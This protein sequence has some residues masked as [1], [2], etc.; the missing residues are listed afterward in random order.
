MHLTAVTRRTFRLIMLKYPSLFSLSSIFFILFTIGCSR[1]ILK[2]PEPLP[3]I[4]KEY[5][6]TKVYGYTPGMQNTGVYLKEGDFY[7]LFGSGEIKKRPSS[8]SGHIP[9][10]HTVGRIGNEPFFHLHV[11]DFYGYPQKATNSGKLYLGILE[12]ETNEYGSSLQ[13]DYYKNNSGHFNI[14]II[15]WERGDWA[16]FVD[17]F[18]KLKLQDPDNQHLNAALSY[19]RKQKEFYLAETNTTNEVK[20]IERE[21]E[22]LKEKPDVT[23][24]ETIK[25]SSGEEPLPGATSSDP[26]LTKQERITYLE[27]KLAQLTTTLTQLEEMKRKWEQERAKTTLLA[28]ELEEQQRK[29]QDLLIKLEQSVKSPP[30]IIIASPEEGRTSEAPLITLSGVAVD[31]QGLKQLE[32]FINGV[33]VEVETGR[34]IKIVEKEYPK[35][36]NFKHRIRLNK[37]D[38]LIKI[39]AVDSD[40]LF[41]EKQLT[42]HKIERRRK[43]WAVVIGINNYPKVR[44]L[45]YAVNDAN[46]VYQHLVNYTKIPSENVLLLLNQDAKLT[47]LRSTL[48]TYLK[49]KAGKEDMV[50]IYFAGHGATE[51]DVTSPDGDGLEK[52]LL[53]HDVDPKDLY[54][55]AL[56]MGE[57]S[58]IFTRIQSERLIFIADSCYSGASGGRTIKIAETR[59]NISD[60]FLDRIAVGRGKII[61]T[62]SGASEVSE[63]KENLQHGVF[64]YFLL[65]A[66]R[67]NADTDRDGLVTVDEVYRYVSTHVPEATGQGQHP[68]KKGTVEGQLVL[69]FVE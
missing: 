22:T 9:G 24:A 32:V 36:L 43:I 27:T 66:L 15:V 38:N 49:N 25:G 53:P 33:A 61:L 40:G 18:E 48:G 35:R 59:A 65:E 57:I 64:T 34:G 28:K 62:A 26:K 10:S 63:E 2:M 6:N 68:V 5:K 29:E 58:R 7:S 21:I 17:F 14:D 54:A 47:K 51:K 46:A 12:G 3:P 39:R 20:K 41:T 42:V 44:H 52:Y 19:A 8:P 55:T 4:V 30:F 1:P 11:M 23:K 69:G 31:D 16:Q 56:P 13:P 60:A 67:G 45:K 37:G 50:I